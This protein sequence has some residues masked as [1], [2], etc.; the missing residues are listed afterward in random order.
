MQLARIAP[1]LTTIALLLCPVALASTGDDSEWDADRARHLWNRAGFGARAGQVERAL[2]LGREAQVAELVAGA[3]SDP[4]FYEPIE[5]IDP[6]EYAALGEEEQRKERNRVQAENRKLLAQ[7]AGWWVEEL[8]DGR[9]PLRERMTLFWHG[10]FTSSARD[11]RD[12]A[13]MIAQIEMLRQHALGRFDELLKAVVRDPAM[14]EYLDNNQNRRLNPNENFARELMEL[15]TLGEGHYTEEDVKEAARALTGWTTRRGDPDPRFQARRHDRGPKT[16]LGVSGDFDADGLVDLLL[17]Q[18]ACAR[19]LAGRLIE[20]FEGRAPD[21]RRLA[22]YADFLSKNEYR[23]DLFLTR[24]FNDE[25]FYRP[26]IVGDK[27]AGPIEYLVGTARRLGSEPPGEL[28]WLAA[29]QL[30]QRLLDPPNVKGWEGGR[31]WITTSTYLQRG[32]FAGMMLGVVALEDVLAAEPEP[33]ADDAMME[34]DDAEPAPASEVD[35]SDNRAGPA[36]ARRAK[37]ARE[38]QEFGQVRRILAGSGY[39]PG[40]HL[41]ARARRA[42]AQSDAQIVEQLAG[43][44]LAVPLSDE[45]RATLLEFLA[46]ERAALGVDEGRLFERDHAVEAEKLLRRLAHLLLSLPEAQLC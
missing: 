36:A 15:F 8:L 21:A 31:A 27:I 13:A 4:F 24:L 19:H 20:E 38:P 34:A 29:G 17:A 23:I 44:L 42:G 39:R 18:P 35:A 14:L 12:S 9:D 5:R 6:A 32:N 16:I 43:E 28:L 3:F 30:G 1:T 25:A 26:E 37:R 7:F 11:V 2:E 46:R 10:Y 33:E 45:G 40:V 41:S 22:D